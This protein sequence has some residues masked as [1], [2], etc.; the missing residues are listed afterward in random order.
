MTMLDTENGKVVGTV[1]IGTGVD[2]CAFDPGTS[3]A[4]ASCGEGTITI[5]KEEGRDKLTV[6]QTLKT[7]RGARTM[8][9]DPKT[10]RIYT[11]TAQV[12]SDQATPAPG[13]KWR[14]PTYVPETFH[15]L[16]YGPE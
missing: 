1:P 2:G 10:H 13:E 16:V 11:A 9:L 6:F 4:F 5:A 14:R 15:L 3:L 7:E 8:A 12:A